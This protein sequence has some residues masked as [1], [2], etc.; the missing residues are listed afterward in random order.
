M[1]SPNMLSKAVCS[2][3]LFLK[4]LL[5]DHQLLALICHVATVTAVPFLPFPPDVT[6]SVPKPTR[7]P[8]FG[9]GKGNFQPDK[10][11]SSEGQH[12][13]ATRGQVSSKTV[14]MT[15]NFNQDGVGD[16]SDVS[17]TV[18]NPLLDLEIS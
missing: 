18:I 7:T 15:S 3:D 11:I 8:F 12:P 10:P 2:S 9:S 17:V 16:G 13:D 4:K 5:T 6:S 1:L 14:A